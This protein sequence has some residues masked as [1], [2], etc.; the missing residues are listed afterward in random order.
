[1]TCSFGYHEQEHAC[2]QIVKDLKKL[3][4][5]QTDTFSFTGKVLRTEVLGEENG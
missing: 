2:C 4:E 3:L 5:G 1:M